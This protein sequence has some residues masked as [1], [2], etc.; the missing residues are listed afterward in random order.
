VKYGMMKV[1]VHADKLSKYYGKGG[2]IKAVDE[3]IAQTETKTLEEPFIAITGGVKE[4]EL[5]AWREQRGAA[6]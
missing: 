2:E 1:V 4:K 3:T 5:L 6:A